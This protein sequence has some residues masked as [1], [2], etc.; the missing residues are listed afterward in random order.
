MAVFNFTV[1]ATDSE[2]SYADRQFNITVRNSRVERF[3][4]ITTNDA[5]TSPDATSWTQRVGAGGWTCAYGNGF[6][7]IMKSATTCEIAKSTDGINYNAIP[8][9]EMTFLDPA[10]AA[11]TAPTA[12]SPWTFYNKMKFWNGRF[13]LLHFANPSGQKKTLSLWSTADGVTWKQKILTQTAGTSTAMSAFSQGYGYSL[14]TEDGNTLFIPFPSSSGT[15]TLLDAANGF[16]PCMG[17]STTDG[18]TFTPIRNSTTTTTVQG[19]TS[20]TRFNGLYIAN[21]TVYNGTTYG[22]T[23]SQFQYIYS[24]DGVN[25]TAGDYSLS[26]SGIN[27]TIRNISQYYAWNPPVYANGQLFLFANKTSS[28]TVSSGLLYLTSMD[29][30]VWDRVDNI[31]LFNTANCFTNVIY[32]NGVF[33]LSGRNTISGVDTSTTVTN[34]NTGYRVSID[35][36][37]W[38]NNINITSGSPAYNDSAAM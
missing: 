3:M 35:G 2:G 37:N 18:E 7:L 27:S 36:V 14:M 8:T 19:S 31:K 25:W 9:S 28:T 34:P 16:T 6:W 4:T 29:G 15:A 22:V 23:G 20:I 30:L 10:G 17:W 24:T 11:T 21:N 1:R 33:L 32:K 26:S 38:D 12:V 13:Y 5:W